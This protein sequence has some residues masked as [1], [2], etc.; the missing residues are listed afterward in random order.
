LQSQD[1]LKMKLE[2]SAQYQIQNLKAA[3]NTQMQILQ[4]ENSTLR[5]QIDKKNLELEDLMDK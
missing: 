4:D 1:E 3:F 5:N 2:G